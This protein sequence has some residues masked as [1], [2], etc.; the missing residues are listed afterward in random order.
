MYILLSRSFKNKQF[1]SQILQT[2]NNFNKTMD[3]LMLEFK[4]TISVKMLELQIT[5]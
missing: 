5:F 1:H 3:P 2:N 4:R